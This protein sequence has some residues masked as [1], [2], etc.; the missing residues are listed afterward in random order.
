MWN[1]ATILLIAIG[2]SHNSALSQDYQPDSLLT[3]HEFQFSRLMY[4]G[5]NCLGF[6]Y[7]WGSDECVD[8]PHAEH[9]FMQ[10]LIRLTRINGAIV[11]RHDGGGGRRITL[12]D[13]SLFNFF[14]ALITGID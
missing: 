10:G 9:H 3:N 14:G 4:A 1:F 8:W 5:G 7:G 13:D 6:G 2:G 11:S 12:E